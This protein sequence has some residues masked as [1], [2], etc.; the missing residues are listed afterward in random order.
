MTHYIKLQN[1]DSAGGCLVTLGAG[2]AALGPA[3]RVSVHAQQAVLLLHAEPHA[4]LLRR[5]HHFVTADA[6]VR[7]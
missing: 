5:L 6:A 4:V 1:R 3:V 2:E 7:L